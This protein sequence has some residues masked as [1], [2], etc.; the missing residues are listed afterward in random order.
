MLEQVTSVLDRTQVKEIH[1]DDLF[2]QSIGASLKSIPDQRSK[3]FAK[4]KIQ[5][6]IFQA[7]FG[8]L[9]TPPDAPGITAIFPVS[10]RTPPSYS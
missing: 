5:E 8:L 6:I 10:K 4:V 9:A 2:G 7:R 3:E 1:A